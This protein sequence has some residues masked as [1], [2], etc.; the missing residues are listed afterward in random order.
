MVNDLVRRPLEETWKWWLAL[1]GPPIAWGAR[2]LAGWTIA[3]VACD[4]GWADEPSYYV[5][6]SLVLAVGVT[7]VAGSVWA[8]LSALRDEREALEFDTAGNYA[9][10]SVV[11]LLSAAIFGLLIVVEGSAVYI[12]GCGA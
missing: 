8:A 5:V 4:R 12:V 7:V 3:E 2:L 11:A 10:L 1:F 9:F 6:Q